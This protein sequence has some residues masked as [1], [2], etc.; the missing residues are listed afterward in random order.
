MLFPSRRGG[1]VV[2]LFCN[3]LLFFVVALVGGGEGSEAIVVD[4]D[5]VVDLIRG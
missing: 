4:L 2:P 1:D 5:V 3:L